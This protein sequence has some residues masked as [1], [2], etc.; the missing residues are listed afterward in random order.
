MVVA[1]V[2]DGVPGSL[3]RMSIQTKAPLSL[4]LHARPVFVPRVRI[5]SLSARRVRSTLH[6]TA[7]LATAIT[8]AIVI[9]PLPFFRE[10]ARAAAGE[11][12]AS[13]ERERPRQMS[14]VDKIYIY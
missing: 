12:A 7:R 9:I 6:T 13:E 4:L 2:P 10:R 8:A 5:S 1:V 11:S 14:V 3:S